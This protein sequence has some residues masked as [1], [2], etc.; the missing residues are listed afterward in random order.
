LVKTDQ[1]NLHAHGY[2]L[3]HL[4]QRPETSDAFGHWA[5]ELLRRFDAF[6]VLCAVREGPR[7]VAGINDAI[8][9]EAQ[10]RGWLQRRGIWYEGRPVM[11]IRNDSGLGLFNGDTGLVLRAPGAAG[12]GDAGLRAWFLSAGRLHSVAVSRLP[13]VE[14]AFAMTVHKSQGSEFDHVLLVLPDEDLPLL[15]RE[16]IYTGMTRAR[17]RLSMAYRSEATLI[18]AVGRPTWRMSGLRF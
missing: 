3:Q 7:G 10:A 16:L 6:R 8:E 13:E 11:V 1:E 18:Q 14:T 5:T 17:R 2:W 4:K 12:L 9:R 15:T